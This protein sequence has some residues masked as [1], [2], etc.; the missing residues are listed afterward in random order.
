MMECQSK[1]TTA[2]EES[3]QEHCHRLCVQQKSNLKFAALHL[4]KRNLNGEKVGR[5]RRDRESYRGNSKG[6]ASEALF[7]RK[8][9]EESRRRSGREKYLQHNCVVFSLWYLGL[10]EDFWGYHLPAHIPW[11]GHSSAGKQDQLSEQISSP[12]SFSSCVPTK[13]KN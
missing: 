10:Q 2:Q 9:T 6:K 13:W 7:L 11:W 8:S 4:R 3:L 1:K 5:G 12:S